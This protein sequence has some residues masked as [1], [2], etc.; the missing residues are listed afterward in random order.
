MFAVAPGG[1]VGFALAACKAE[2]PA[3][4]HRRCA[5]FQPHEPQTPCNNRSHE[6]RMNDIVRLPPESRGRLRQ[7]RADP[8]RN[9]C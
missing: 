9:H 6:H 5:G 1:R 8:H 4:T 7:P 2:P 3:G